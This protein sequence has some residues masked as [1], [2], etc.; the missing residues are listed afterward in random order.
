MNLMLFRSLWTNGFDLDAALA[1]CLTG[2]F[3]GVEGPVANKDFA[4]KLRDARVPFIAEITTGGG[5]VPGQTVTLHEHIDSFSHKIEASLE[6][7]PLLISVLAGC[8][9]WS[10]QRNV[11]FFG[12]ALE[13]AREFGVAVS[14]ET[15]RSRSMFNPWIARDL[16]TQLP[17]LRL[18]CDFSHW[19]CVCE[20]LVM[21]GE[22]ELLGLCAERT[23]HVH[24]RIGYA[25]GPQVPHPAA[26][27]YHEALY[28]H[29]RWWDAIWDSQQIRQFAFATM[30]P[31][32]GPDGYLHST[33]FSGKPVADLD[34]INR[35]MAVRQRN[36]FAS[37]TASPAAA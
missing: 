21:D 24:A 10:L 7:E 26:P 36:R 31:E 20:R 16:L 11:E 33:P 14:F 34:E 19:C 32:F 18:T 6:C 15:H 2:N 35:W 22:Q 27:E 28:A 13:I 17:D 4:A 23:L 8:D 30:T 1:D 25:Q 3:D 12:S 29:E 5:Y 9:A 37:R